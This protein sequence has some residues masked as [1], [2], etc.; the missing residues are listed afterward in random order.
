MHSTGESRHLAHPRGTSQLN[1]HTPRPRKHYSVFQ[2]QRLPSASTHKDDFKN[3]P[4]AA[5]IN[6]LQRTNL[7]SADSPSDMPGF[8]S[9]LY[10]GSGQSSHLTDPSL[11]T[12][13][14]QQD[15]Q[16]EP[17]TPCMNAQAPTK[18]RSDCIFDVTSTAERRVTRTVEQLIRTD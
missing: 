5:P 4:I 15:T 12:R 7:P 13:D 11:R 2:A 17:A 16:E 3:G 10:T 1:D 14:K 8:N 18:C 6:S 9:I